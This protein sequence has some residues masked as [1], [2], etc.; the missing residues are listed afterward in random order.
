MRSTIS[1][2]II[3]KLIVI[4]IESGVSPK[5]LKEIVEK[6]FI[7]PIEMIAATII[8]GID[9]KIALI[10]FLGS[11]IGTHPFLIRSKCKFGLLFGNLLN[12]FIKLPQSHLNSR[13]FCNYPAQ[14]V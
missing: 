5:L 10:K 7:T 1:K 8:K 13:K 2:K 3:P 4:D 14:I 6:I 9:N 12:T 11:F